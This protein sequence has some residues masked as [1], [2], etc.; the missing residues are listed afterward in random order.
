MTEDRQACTLA[1][2]GSPSPYRPECYKSV[3]VRRYE[4]KKV[5]RHTAQQPDAGTQ[6][7]C[8][9]VVAAGRTATSLGVKDRLRGALT[10]VRS[11][12][13]EQRFA[14]IHQVARAWSG[15][16]DLRPRRGLRVKPGAGNAEP[17]RRGASSGI[18]SLQVP[19][20]ERAESGYGASP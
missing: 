12:A 15:R 6:Q 7:A 8:L 1:P 5:A 3:E 11:A 20:P 14:V 16:L 13:E 4:R 9:P 2:Q 19:R 10:F 17:R 18:A